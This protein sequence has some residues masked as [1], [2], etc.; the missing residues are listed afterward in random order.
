MN[1][2]FL[3]LQDSVVE[4]T[5]TEAVKLVLSSEN[6]LAQK[7]LVHEAV[8]VVDDFSLEN[9]AE[10]CR[11]IL[12]ALVSSLLSTDSNLATAPLRQESALGIFQLASPEEFEPLMHIHLPLLIPCAVLRVSPASETDRQTLQNIQAA[13]D[14]MHSTALNREALQTMFSVSLKLTTLLPELLP[15]LTGLVTLFLKE[16]L[17]CKAQRFADAL[18]TPGDA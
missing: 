16:L 8:C 10:T 14:A 2:R 5:I 9:L 17:R 7:M 18:H 13:L 1:C 15:G 6:T 12:R 3:N 11:L 4:E